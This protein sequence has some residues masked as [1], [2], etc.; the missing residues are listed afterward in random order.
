MPWND[1]L[2]GTAL[3]IAATTVSPLRVLAG[4]GTGKSFAMMKRVQR[5]LEEGVDPASML[6]CTFTRTAAAD[7]QQ[8]LLQV[9]APH[10]ADVR[11]GT[12]H[13]L[14]FS[15]LSRADV[16]AVTG[17][18]PRPL[19]KF[20]ERFLLEDV[21]GG[22][23]GGVRECGKRLRAFNAAWSRLQHD[24]PGWPIDAVDRRF[25]GTLLQWLLFHEAILIGELVPELLKYLRNNPHAEARSAFQ[26]VLVDEYQDLN[27]AEQVVLELIAEAGT[28]A[29][30]G[31]E[32]QSIYSFKHAHPEGISQFHVTH[33]GT[34]DEQLE[35]CRRCPQT[36]VAMANALIS[37]NLGRTPRAMTPKPENP[38]GE[39][40]VVQWRSM[41]A[42][43]QGLAAFIKQRIQSGTVAP[44]QVLVLAPRR[45]FGYAIRDALNSTGVPAHSFFSEQALDGDPKVLDDSKAQQALALL[46]LL[47]DPDDRVALRCWC[48]FGSTSLNSG[49][50]GR[51]RAHAEANSMSPRAVLAA[52]ADGTLTLSHTSRVVDRY[53]LLVQRTAA[54]TALRGQAL[55]D[56]LL[57][58]G[59]DWSTSLREQAS[60]IDEED[61]DL[62]TLLESIRSAVTQPELPTDVD[63]VRIMSLHKSKGLTADLVVVAGCVEGLI[64][65]ID[66]DLEGD[67][68]ARAIAEQ[69]RVFYV[70][71]T[72]PRKALLLSSVVRLPTRLAHKMRV[73]VQAGGGNTARTIASRFLGE[74]GPSCPAAITGESFLTSQ[75]VATP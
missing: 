18:T 55:C 67:E 54:L 45:Q 58:D 16:L 6:V 65:T 35:M 75:G 5:L 47:V 7:L 61:Y 28:L 29:I 12:L 59:Q 51:V 56:Q 11:A 72:R 40:F 74:L 60:F 62:P 42:E 43:A 27:R 17:R 22:E 63:Y 44:G 46:T 48:G 13:S 31:D 33:P 53:R 49:A 64:P 68:R 21:S 20:E 15:V 10:A 30:I 26:H 24:D 70:A 36:V 50:W 57:P 39:M 19:M 1:G 71:I 38:Q 73:R 14:A 25:S 66:D 23:F 52:L 32:D 3:R 9:Q 41:A 8:S 69:R 37:H 2:E 34:Q 4:P